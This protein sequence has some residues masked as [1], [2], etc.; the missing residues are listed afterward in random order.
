M[1]APHCFVMV[2]GIP[3]SLPLP[4]KHNKATRSHEAKLRQFF[5]ERD[6]VGLLICRFGPAGANWHKPQTLEVC[7]QGGIVGKSW[8]I[9]LEELL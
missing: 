9:F 7:T 5:V 8:E 2:V 6:L 4:I 1:K 3:G